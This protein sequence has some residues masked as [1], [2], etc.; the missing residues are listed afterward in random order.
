MLFAERLLT[1]DQEILGGSCPGQEVRRLPRDAACLHIFE[2]PR[3]CLGRLLVSASHSH[4]Q[5]SCYR[6]ASVP[7]FLALSSV[8]LSFC[9]L[10][11]C[12]H[13]GPACSRPFL[14]LYLFSSPL[15]GRSSLSRQGFSH[16]GPR[17]CSCA[18]SRGQGGSREIDTRYGCPRLSTYKEMF[19]FGDAGVWTDITTSKQTTR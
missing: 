1:P 5:N 8:A 9:I 14:S 19:P 18:L 6:P 4:C 12:F 17:H 15:S 11:F 3:A 2:L 16:Q 7:C 13:A 10:G